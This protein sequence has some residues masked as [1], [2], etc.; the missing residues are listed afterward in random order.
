MSWGARLL[1]AEPQVARSDDGRGFALQF[2]R[3]HGWEHL[4]F[5]GTFETGTTDVLQRLLQPDDV[6]FDIGANIGWYTTLFGVRCPRGH[7]HA[8]EPDPEV[9]AELTTNCALN[10]LG[11]SVTLNNLGVSDR[12]GT[13]TIYRF[14]EL[15]H[16]HS[17]LAPGL[18][19]RAEGTACQVTTL[20]R[21]R[22]ERGIERI[23]LIKVDVEGAELLV[24]NGADR[25]RSGAPAPMWV[26]EVNFEASA[27]FGYTP[28]D[29]FRFLSTRGEFL[30]FR[31]IEGWG[32]LVPMDRIVECAQSDNVL[33]VP[34]ERLARVAALL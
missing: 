5:T 8:F 17:S 34:I 11:N 31:I 1:G 23:D 18:G 20:D 15:P 25:V 16:G 29:L 27:A 2:P 12:A 4:Q 13:T 7:C 24:L 33:C 21:Y 6:T 30:F 32:K 19:A 28:P 14:A 22:A 10:R 26:L 3:D 9:F